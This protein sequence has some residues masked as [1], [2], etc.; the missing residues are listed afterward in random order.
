MRSCVQLILSYDSSVLPAGKVAQVVHGT[1]T[2]RQVWLMCLEEV[3]EG[4]QDLWYFAL[5]FV[6]KSGPLLV[7]RLNVRR[8]SWQSRSTAAPEDASVIL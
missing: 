6:Q 7:G 2:Q 4:P 3:K 8:F 1:L 5:Q